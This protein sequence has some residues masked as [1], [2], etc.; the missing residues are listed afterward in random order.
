MPKKT[1]TIS[2]RVQR[3]TS[4]ADE[5]VSISGEDPKDFVTDLVADL[6]HY[7]AAKG[8]P[9]AACLRRAQMHITAEQVEGGGR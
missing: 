5:Y 1:T 6:M 3:V 4:I 8:I 9:L 2:T 7:S